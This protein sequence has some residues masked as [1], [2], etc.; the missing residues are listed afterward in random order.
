VQRRSDGPLPGHLGELGA[1]GVAQALG[2]GSQHG[3][4]I[5]GDAYGHAD[6]LLAPPCIH[7]R[8]LE[9]ASILAGPGLRQR[10]RNKPRH[11]KPPNGQDAG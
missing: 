6:G 2:Q 4:E 7:E 8:Q 5:G 3:H 1:L 11:L 10:L 9:T